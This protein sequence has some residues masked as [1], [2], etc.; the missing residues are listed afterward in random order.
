MPTAPAK[1]SFLI[2]RAKSG[3][4]RYSLDGRP[5]TGVTTV[6]N[7]QSK[8][9]LVTWAASEAYK[10]CLDL[11]KDQIKEVIKTKVYAHTKKSDDSKEKGTA[12]HGYVETFVKHFIETGQYV[13]EDIPD[14]EVKT[15][16]TR[17]YDWAESKQV[18][19]LASEVSVYSRI[20]WYAGTFDFICEIDGKTLL[21]D[22][23]T[24]KQMDGTYLAQG[25]GYVIAVEENETD[26]HFDGIVI[27]RSILAKEG[28]VWYERSSNGKSKRMV[29][30][31][32]EVL[33]SYDLERE[34]TYFLSLLNLYRYNKK[35]QV[36]K[37]Y[38]AEEVDFTEADY[39]LYS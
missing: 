15:S 12:A 5:L 11:D 27:V 21:G 3:R 31:P 4:G 25:A 39:P 19:F 22:F 38:K 10:D 33:Y 8:G 2:D 34:K 35:L 9:F 13:R 7:E 29:N 30:E 24:S 16:V 6:C 18:K 36:S 17:F 32:F 14:E 20:F 37:W 28:R 1:P 23:K 26:R